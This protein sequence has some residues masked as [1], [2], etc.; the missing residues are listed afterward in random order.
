MHIEIHYVYSCKRSQLS[1]IIR[2]SYPYSTRLQGSRLHKHILII[3]SHLLY[4]IQRTPINTIRGY[5]GHLNLWC[6]NRIDVP[7]KTCY[8]KYGTVYCCSSSRLLSRKPNPTNNTDTLGMM[9]ISLQM[10]NGLLKPRVT[11]LI[12]DGLGLQHMVYL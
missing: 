5:N 11:L 4:S 12:N 10:S 1:K 2:N 3:H 6:D 8:H 7:L 9:S